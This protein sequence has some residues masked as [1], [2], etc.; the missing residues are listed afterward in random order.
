MHQ[1]MGRNGHQDVQWTFVNQW[2]DTKWEALSGIEN[3]EQMFV[4][5]NQHML[6]AVLDSA[7]VFDPGGQDNE[8]EKVN[9]NIPVQQ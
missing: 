3:G 9:Q 5:Y 1:S 8:M 4:V 7:R 2:G 6:I